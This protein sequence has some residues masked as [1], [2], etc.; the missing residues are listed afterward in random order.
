MCVFYLSPKVNFHV[1]NKKKGSHSSVYLKKYL[2]VLVL[3]CVVTHRLNKPMID[4]I[5]LFH[6]RYSFTFFFSL[7]L[8]PLSHLLPLHT[9]HIK[10]QTFSDLSDR[11]MVQPQV[12]SFS[13]K[14]STSG[15]CFELRC[16][17]PFDRR[18]CILGRAVAGDAILRSSTSWSR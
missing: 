16:E 2:L 12:P 13:V 4:L 1:D 15:M 8:S 3:M 14:E 7:P 6:D 9:H 5:F 18:W 11:T 17:A 10:I